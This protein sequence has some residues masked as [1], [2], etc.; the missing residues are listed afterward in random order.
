M[1]GSRFFF[2]M[3]HFLVFES[4]MYLRKSNYP[5]SYFT[6]YR[7]TSVVQAIQKDLKF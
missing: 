5:K 1:E 4:I 3:K 2:Q 6:K 7:N